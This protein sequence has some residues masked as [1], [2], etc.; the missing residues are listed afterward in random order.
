MSRWSFLLAGALLLSPLSAHAQNTTERDAA[1]AKAAAAVAAGAASE[2]DAARAKA[3]AAAAAARRQTAAD[4]RFQLF[5]ASTLPITH[6]QMISGEKASG[7]W[8]LNSPP[9]TSVAV[10]AFRGLSFASPGACTHTARVTFTNGVTKT[11]AIDFCGK[12][13]KILYVSNKDMWIE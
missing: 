8:L 11:R 4:T 2:R 10:N 3:A 12:P 6:F 9:G 7:N 13:K 1:R 5:N